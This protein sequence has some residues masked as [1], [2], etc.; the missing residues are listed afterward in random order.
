MAWTVAV[1]G[2]SN[3]PAP[4]AGA[5]V[6]AVV[7][8]VR[9][10]EQAASQ[11]SEEAPP[12]GP[13]AGLGE[14]SDQP[15]EGKV[16]VRPPWPEQNLGH[17]GT[18]RLGRMPLLLPPR[19]VERRPQPV[20]PV[21]PDAGE[22]ALGEA[23]GEEAAKACGDQARD[24]GWM[25]ERH[26]RHGAAR[27]ADQVQRRGRLR[28]P[29]P[30]HA[31][32]E[33]GELPEFQHLEVEEQLQ[34][35]RGKGE[36]GHDPPN[37]RVEQEADAGEGAVRGERRGRRPDQ[38]IGQEAVAG[39][40]PAR[41]AAEPGLPPVH[42]GIY[43]VECH[44]QEMEAGKGGKG[45]AERGPLL[46]SGGIERSRSRRADG[47][48]RGRVLPAHPSAVVSIV[49][50]AAPAAEA[51]QRAD[52]IFDHAPERDALLVGVAGLPE[53]P[54]LHPAPLE[55]RPE[56]RAR[57]GRLRPP[58]A[59]ATAAA[60][61][62]FGRSSGEA[63]RV[64]RGRGCAPLPRAPEAH[65]VLPSPPGEE[66]G[67]L[68]GLPR[69]GVPAA[70]ATG[71][72]AAAAAAAAL[73]RRLCLRLR[74]LLPPGKPSPPLDVV[75]RI[76][77]RVLLDLQLE[78]KVV[79][80]GGPEGR[81][82]EVVPRP[83]PPP[84]GRTGGGGLPSPFPVPGHRGWGGIVGTGRG[85]R[86]AQRRGPGGR[87]SH[88]RRSR[89]GGP[90]HEGGEAAAACPGTRR[91]RPGRRGPA[92]GRKGQTP[93]LPSPLPPGRGGVVGA[94]RRNAGG[95]GGGQVVGGVGAVA[96]LGQDGGLEHGRRGV[97]RG[98]R[99]GIEARQAIEVEAE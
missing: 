1:A 26:H 15:L 81:L 95:G 3:V 98:G 70:T 25:V 63:G 19:V 85:G 94:R 62:H 27:G 79:G 5:P 36:G 83:G 33:A 21:L 50:A 68:P 41:R 58:P 64:R 39:K 59:S 97:R 89:L 30:L 16:H 52:E 69:V 48:V 90:P 61:V 8:Q 34:Q 71:A 73:L 10:V 22:P 46:R 99:A 77:F 66:R 93:L 80:Q 29:A 47:T 28:R 60:C 23:G 92:R 55:G 12:H 87:S 86:R 75:V 82:V 65:P 56:R 49:V 40:P 35:R 84:A 18:V 17:A 14:A 72:A 4:P 96:A 11:A 13:A 51:R 67:S 42:E 78:A 91:A 57:R 37:L 2:G 45:E 24:V 74:P 9:K 6:G 54:P 7:E 31:G 88:V 32:D 20:R 76:P 43:V 44:D 53:L 38:G